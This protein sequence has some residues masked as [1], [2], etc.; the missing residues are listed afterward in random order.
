MWLMSV[1]L[2]F[3]KCLDIG[4]FQLK[5]YGSPALDYTWITQ[6]GKFACQSS[7]WPLPFFLVK[8]YFTWSFWKG[9]SILSY[10]L[11]YTCIRVDRKLFSENWESRGRGTVHGTCAN[12][13]M[14]QSI[15]QNLKMENGSKMWSRNNT[16][17]CSIGPSDLVKEDAHSASVLEGDLCVLL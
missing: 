17:K 13:F 1:I 6:F 16:N 3:L 10:N 4:H 11:P 2:E 12:C 9:G 5:G 14:H 8:G 15:T 7:F